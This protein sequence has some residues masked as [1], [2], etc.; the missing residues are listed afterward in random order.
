MYIP[1]TLGFCGLSCE[2]KYSK[3]IKITNDKRWI[4]LL[5]WQHRY[6]NECNYSEKYKCKGCTES[7]EKRQIK[8]GKKYENDQWESSMNNGGAEFMKAPGG[9]FKIHNSGQ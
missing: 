1:E 6:A 4:G 7:G 3:Y 8:E 2:D 9:T 5:I